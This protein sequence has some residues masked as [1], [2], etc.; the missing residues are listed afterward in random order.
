MAGKRDRR[1]SLSSTPERKAGFVARS[2][3]ALSVVGLL[4]ASCGSGSQAPVVPGPAVVDVTMVDNSF[5][6]DSRIPAGRVVFRV[7]NGGQV[8][9]RL[10]LV[11]LPSDVPPI[12]EQLHGGVRV[13]ITP[14]AGTP[15]MSPGTR[16]TF[17]VDLRPGQRYALLDFLKDPAAT[18]SHALMGMSSEFKTPDERA[19]S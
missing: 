17:A 13:S 9:H 8:A 16:D 15:A 5:Q 6:Y 18:E 12:N 1:G 7:A 2:C 11:P 14:F 3:L 4:C 10:T 19:P